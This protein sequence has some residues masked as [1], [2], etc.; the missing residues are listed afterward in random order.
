MH[1]QIL[2]PFLLRRLKTDVE[3]AL[4]PKKEVLVYAPLTATQQR[5]YQSL[6]NNTIMKMIEE[7]RCVGVGGCVWVCTQVLHTCIYCS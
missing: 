4:P 3:F 2:T 7:E 6:L 5:Y 1:T